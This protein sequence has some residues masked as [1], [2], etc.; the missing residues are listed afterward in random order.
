MQKNVKLFELGSYTVELDPV[1]TK[2]AMSTCA[3][4]EPDEVLSLFRF[5]LKGARPE[6]LSFLESLGIEPSQIPMARPLAPPDEE[7]NVLF[8]CTARLCGKV[9]RGGDTRPRQSEEEAGISMVFVSQK[10]EFTSGLENMFET[11]IEIRFVME[12]PFDPSF[13]ERKE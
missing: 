12:R 9:L 7:G 5:L 13:F 8:L 6:S 2:A 4:K 1:A 3:S 11:E 10:E